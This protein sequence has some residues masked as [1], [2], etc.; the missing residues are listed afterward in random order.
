ML[1]LPPILNILL[2]F[3]EEHKFYIAKTN[4]IHATIYGNEDVF[5]QSD[6]HTIIF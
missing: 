1:S 2:V 4:V 5:C 6:F 3:Y